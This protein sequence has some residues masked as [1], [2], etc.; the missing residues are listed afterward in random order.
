MSTLNIPLSHRR[1]KR[2]PLYQPRLS[3]I[4]TLS[5]TLSGSIYPYSEQMS[6]VPKI[7]EALR[8]ECMFFNLFVFSFLSD[9]FIWHLIKIVAL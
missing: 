2:H 3:P 6:M 9:I 4:L 5:L 8:F 7:F 1:S